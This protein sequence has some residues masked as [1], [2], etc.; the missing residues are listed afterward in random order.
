MLGFWIHS[1]GLLEADTLCRECHREHGQ[2]SKSSPSWASY[3]H[4]VEMF[5]DFLR[6]LLADANEFLPFTWGLVTLTL[7]GDQGSHKCSSRLHTW[8]CDE[9]QHETKVGQRV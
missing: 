2:L 8:E 5:P 3:S 4:P 6:M 9:R 7:R 1:Q